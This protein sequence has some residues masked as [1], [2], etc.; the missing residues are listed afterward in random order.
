[1]SDNLTAAELAAEKLPPLPILNGVTALVRKPEDVE[2][3]NSVILAWVIKQIEGLKTEL[4]LAEENLAHAVKTKLRQTGWKRQVKLW[5]NRVVYYGKMQA[6][7]EQ[8]YFIMPDLPNVIDI[9]AV[10]TAQK[11]THQVG[12]GS[13]Q[14][15]AENDIKNIEA[16]QLPE[17]EG[18]FVDPAPFTSVRTR[19]V[20][21]HNQRTGKD[22]TNTVHIVKTT[23]IDE[24]MDFPV[25]AVR[26]QV[27]DSTGIAIARK[28]FD[29]LG[30]IQP[31]TGSTR[32]GDPIVVGRIKR[33]E[34]VKEIGC[35]FIIHWWVATEDL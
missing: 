15:S 12:M 8:G 17:G 20:T 6:A 7:L 21:S 33:K 32:K 34:G 23:G 25:K 9:F 35:S 13:Y 28:L 16:Q 30:I 5:S 3:A 2:I 24:T 10:R 22:E 18:R 11:S 1:M 27:L 4:A 26:P 14:W 31:H 19:Q 29:E